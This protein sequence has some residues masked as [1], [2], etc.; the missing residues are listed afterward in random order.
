V[1][2]SVTTHGFAVNVNNDLQP[3]EWVVPCGIENVRM[4][5][6]TRELGTEQDME[7]YM[8]VVS[9]RF[10]E[11]FGRRVVPTEPKTLAGLVGEPAPV[12]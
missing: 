7:G 11:I 4:T 6:L 1:S 9:R 10:G 3:F 2:R 5:S 8:D 12:R